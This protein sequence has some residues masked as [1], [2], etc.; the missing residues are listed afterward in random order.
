[1]DAVLGQSRA[2]RVVDDAALVVRRGRHPSLDTLDDRDV[3]L[4]KDLVDVPD[5]FELG[6]SSR[7]V[8]KKK[9][10]VSR[11]RSGPAGTT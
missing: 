2:G 4:L 9:S 8:S 5:G 10:Q 11:V 7:S 1:M 3:L 6:P